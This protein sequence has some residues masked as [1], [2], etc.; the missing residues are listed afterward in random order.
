MFLD[1]LKKFNSNLKKLNENEKYSNKKY[2]P[3]VEYETK[4]ES[5]FLDLENFKRIIF[6]V[7]QAIVF[8]DSSNEQPKQI[9]KIKT[10]FND[11]YLEFTQPITDHLEFIL[12]DG[13]HKNVE[14]C[15]LGYNKINDNLAKIVFF[16]ECIDHLPDTMVMSFEIY[17]NINTRE[18]DK[19]LTNN[20]RD[21]KS[22]T[23]YLNF[24][25]WCCFYMMAKSVNIVVDGPT[26]QQRRYCERKN[27]PIPEPW[28]KVIVDPKIVRKR[29][30]ETGTG[31]TVGYRF[32][33]IGHLRIQ[34]RG[35]KE[36]IEWIQPHQRGLKND[37]YIPATYVVEAGRKI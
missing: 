37:I 21:L 14:I 28:H 16:T 29:Q 20:E 34:R 31:R 12:S 1:K 6:D 5:N 10:P 27:I 19:N 8:M 4:I 9:D 30:A 33:V 15:A 36:W 11:F 22:D 23:F 2:S 25:H 35:D 24:F 32:D 3:W 7:R 13:S 17:F 18:I 26:R